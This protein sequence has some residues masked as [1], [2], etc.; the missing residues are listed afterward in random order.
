M[1]RMIAALPLTKFPKPDTLEDIQTV[2][3]L[4]GWQNVL[5]VAAMSDDADAFAE[6]VWEAKVF[7]DDGLNPTELRCAT[8]GGALIGDEVAYGTCGHCGRRSLHPPVSRPT[9]RRL[10]EHVDKLL[11]VREGWLAVS[12]GV[13]VGFLL[14]LG[15]MLVA[16]L[17]V[18]A[19]MVA[20]WLGGW[21][22]LT[23]WCAAL[24]AAVAL[25]LAVANP[26]RVRP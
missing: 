13:V 19:T 8:C 18:L 14:G 23:L 2:Y 1:R 12:G 21:S 17:G 9:P 25:V 22:S 7:A 11:T 6:P 10:S 16:G 5:V 26:E 20:G 15:V 24:G 3:E 4:E